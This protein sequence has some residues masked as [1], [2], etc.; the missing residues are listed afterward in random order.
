MPGLPMP[1]VTTSAKRRYILSPAVAGGALS[2]GACCAPAGPTPTRTNSADSAVKLPIFMEWTALT[3]RAIPVRPGDRGGVV[4]RCGVARGA[5][6][7]ART[8]RAEHV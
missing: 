6:A 5:R 8:A 1:D 2:G 3:A 4:L 7:G